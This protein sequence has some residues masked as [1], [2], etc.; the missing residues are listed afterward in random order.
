MDPFLMYMENKELA[1]ELLY[2]MVKGQVDTWLEDFDTY[3]DEWRNQPEG[4]TFFQERNALVMDLY[5]DGD[6]VVHKQDL[7]LTVYSV[8]DNHGIA[9]FR[10]IQYE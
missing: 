9:G 4:E 5:V 3:A 2:T 10:R 1:V 7:E 6:G 8:T